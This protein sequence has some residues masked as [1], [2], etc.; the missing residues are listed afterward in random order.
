MQQAVLDQPIQKFGEIFAKHFRCNVVFLKQL[1]IRGVDAGRRHHQTPHPCARLVQAK[2]TLRLN[3]QEPDSLSRNRTI[4]FGGTA[5][6]SVKETIHNAPGQN[7]P[8]PQSN[9]LFK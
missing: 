6:R 9:Q 8:G 3:I 7:P 4:T 1:L 2:V 5:T